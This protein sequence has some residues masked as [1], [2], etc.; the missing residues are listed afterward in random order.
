MLAV[1]VVVVVREDDEPVRHACEKKEDVGAMRSLG[2]ARLPELYT[3]SVAVGLAHVLTIL[4]VSGYAIVSK[5]YHPSA[6]RR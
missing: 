2:A 4:L 6:E 3:S 1:A 5:A